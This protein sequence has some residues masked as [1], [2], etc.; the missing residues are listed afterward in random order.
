MAPFSFLRTPAGIK[1]T[2]AAP[3]SENS[4]FST[5]AAT[6]SQEQILYQSSGAIVA[7]IVVGIIVIFTA[8]LLSLKMYNRRMRTKRELEPKN[9]KA[10]TPSTLG[11]DTS[12]PSRTTT[13]TFVPMDI[14]M[15]NRRP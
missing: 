14:Q 3:V 11:Q 5:D 13:V 15:P 7:A 12:S 2:T 1:M 8:V 6:K 10:T 9:A 4:V